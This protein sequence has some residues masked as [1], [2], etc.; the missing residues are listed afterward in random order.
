MDESTRPVELR[1]SLF[2]QGVSGLGLAGGQRCVGLG[3]TDLLW[4]EDLEAWR[5]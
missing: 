5:S 2:D 3:D 1:T 4:P